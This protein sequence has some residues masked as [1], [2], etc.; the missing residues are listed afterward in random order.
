MSLK[1][2]DL[3]VEYPNGPRAVDYV[4][5]DVPRGEV[6]GLLGPSGCGKSSL[7]RAVAGLVDLRT[8]GV[9]FDGQ[10]MTEVPVHRRG[11]GLM[12]QDGQLFPHRNVAGNIGYGL[13]Q[14]PRDQRRHRVVE[15]LDIVGLT[16][17]EDREV[18][19]LSGGQ[20]QRVA[21][22]RAL[23]PGPRLLLLD[24]PLSSLDRSLREHLATELR[25][26]LTTA[27]ATAIYV[28]H[29]HDEAFTV[30]DSVAV[31][32]R[33]R[34][35]QRD[36][37]AELWRHPATAEI[38]EFLGYGPV[39]RATRCGDDLETPVGTIPLTSLAGAERSEGEVL[40]ALAP[41]A[42]VATEAGG[43]YL[44]DVIGRRFRRGLPEAEVRLPGGQRGVVEGATD[45][46]S[47]LRVTL[48]TSH[49]ALV[50]A[51]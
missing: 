25:D 32:F 8:G 2:D 24:E 27:R 26:I 42:L 16:G 3:V 30:A 44:V 29:D 49:V 4:D 14:L 34:L 48:Q 18:T 40:L 43:G 19:T 5:L 9:N 31:M 46:E 1:L 36:A 23:A 15:L 11:F 21:L 50:G 47:Q 12:F 7:L 37:P 20:R 13:A 51:G 45:G 39:L 22:A 35:L 17:F 41:G 10:E 38:A 6:L 33:G 28:T